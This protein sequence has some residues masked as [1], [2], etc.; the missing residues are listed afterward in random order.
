MP[1]SQGENSGAKT[2]Q[3]QSGGRGWAHLVGHSEGAA[4]VVSLGRAARVGRQHEHA[5]HGVRRLLVL[6]R[7]RS[8]LDTRPRGRLDYYSMETFVFMVDR[9]CTCAILL[10]FHAV[11]A[12]Q[13]RLQP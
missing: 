11:K 7:R 5:Q 13:K 9:Y 8:R 2:H 4:D 12:F 10:A 3:G 6:S 1:D